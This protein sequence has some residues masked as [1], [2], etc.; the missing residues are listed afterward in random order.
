MSY[1]RRRDLTLS[2][3][4]GTGAATFIV[5]IDICCHLIPNSFGKSVDRIEGLISLRDTNPLRVFQWP[6][7][8][9]YIFNHRGINN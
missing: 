5:T 4:Q 3:V 7:I 8:I 6:H 9:L 1:N 2:Y